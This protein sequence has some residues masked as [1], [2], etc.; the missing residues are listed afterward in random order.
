[1]R[2]R[3]ITGAVE[4]NPCGRVKHPDYPTTHVWLRSRIFQET[5][6]ANHGCVNGEEGPDAI[7]RGIFQSERA[8]RRT[9]PAHSRTRSGGLLR[10]I[11]RRPRLAMQVCA[12][13][14]RLAR[15]RSA[16]HV[17]R[18]A[19]VAGQWRRH[20]RGATK[21]WPCWVP[22][23]AAAR[24]ARVPAPTECACETLNSFWLRTPG[25][26]PALD[27]EAW[28]LESEA[29]DAQELPRG[30]HAQSLNLVACGVQVWLQAPA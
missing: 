30:I 7:N 29:S 17:D 3:T 27:P 18:L 14:C 12:P 1:M 25:F 19:V 24:G 16:N 23:A 4:F 6:A 20:R 10:K 9:S 5:L 28:S 26:W 2:P 13:E 11:R 15:N 8:T 22:R 21:L